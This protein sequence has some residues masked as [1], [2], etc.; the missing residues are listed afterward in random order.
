MSSTTCVHTRAFDGLPAAPWLATPFKPPQLAWLGVAEDGRTEGRA[1][2]DA[3]PLAAACFARFFGEVRARDDTTDP[4]HTC[5]SG[6]SCTTGGTTSP[7]R[8]APADV[9]SARR[10]LPAAVVIRRHDCLHEPMADEAH[11]RGCI[12]GVALNSYSSV[13]GAVQDSRRQDDPPP[14]STSSA[15]PSLALFC[16]S[17]VDHLR[18]RDGAEARERERLR[19]LA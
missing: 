9:V 6:S 17:W 16:A 7:R 1:P 13:D 11:V 19:L 5:G 14:S 8:M 2:C 15:R 12:F 10:A 3:A 18:L 4:T